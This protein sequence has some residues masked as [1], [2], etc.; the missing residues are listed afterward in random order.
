M[1]SQLIS[2]TMQNFAMH[3]LS[4][5]IAVVAH[6]AGAANLIISWLKKWNEPVRPYMEGP[7]EKLWKAAFPSMHLYLSL[8]DAL[9]DASSVITGTG[10]ASNLEHNARVLAGELGLY[11]VAVLDHWVNYPMRFVRDSKVQLPDE[12]WVVDQWAFQIAKKESPNI[13]MRLF[14][15]TYLQDQLAT[16]SPA[17]ANGTVL[18]ILEPVRQNW[19]RDQAGEFQALEFALKT[20]DRLYPVGVSKIL[21]RLH[22]SESSDKYEKYLVSDARIEMD[23]SED[24]AAAISFADIVV[25]VE[26]F[27]LSVALEAGRIVYSSLPPWAPALRLPHPGIQQLR[28]L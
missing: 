4:S 6:D 20:I 18:Y 7:A 1:V 17:P 13:S 2:F 12:I 15:N 21:L 26:S 19:G 10:W 16:I 24:L 8:R 27:A 11:S 22:P 23:A 5:P 9:N 14:E 28:N 3:D 25:G